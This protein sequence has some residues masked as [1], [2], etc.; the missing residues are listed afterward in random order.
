MNA[1]FDTIK[2]LLNLMWLM[3]IF[4]MPVQF[5]YSG[6]DGL[7]G[8]PGYAINKYSLGNLGGAES[9]CKIGPVDTDRL[10]LSCNMGLMNADNLTF[11]IIPSSSKITNYCQ[12]SFQNVNITNCTVDLNEVKIR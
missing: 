11:G 2:Y 9:L 3:L 1:Y 5:L 4:T 6:Y 8:Q 12:N 7:K 10:P